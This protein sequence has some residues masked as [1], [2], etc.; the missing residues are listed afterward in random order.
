MTFSEAGFEVAIL[1]G[2]PAGLA[3]GYYAK[4]SGLPFRIFEASP[5][6]GGNSI[7]FHWGPFGYDSGAHRYHDKD[8]GVTEEL[9]SLLGD[10]L[11]KIQVPSQ[12]YQ[13]G[14]LVDFPLSPLNVVIR[15]GL[16]T[17]LRG[18]LDFVRGQLSRPPRFET[19]ESFAVH[20]Y[21]KTI[22]DLFLLNYTEKLWGLPCDRLSPNV[23]GKRLKGLIFT[24]FLK[25]VFLG[26]KA[27]TEHLDGSFYYPGKGIGV[28]PEA[29]ARFCGP[30]AI[31]TNARVT[32]VFHDG[33]AVTGI[34]INGSRQVLAHAAVSTLPL[35]A[36]IA[37]LTP[38]APASIRELAA[39]LEFRDVL[40]VALFVDRP[41]I[42]RNASIYFP[43]REF[44][45]TRLYEPKNRSPE[46]APPDKTCVVLEIPTRRDHPFWSMNEKEL[47]RQVVDSFLKTG[48]IEEREILGSTVHKLPF[49][50]PILEAGFDGKVQSIMDYLRKFRNLKISGRCGKFLYT[51]LHDM[52]MFGRE[53]A[54]ELLQERG[55]IYHGNRKPE[56]VE[57]CP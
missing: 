41:C 30:E 10:D 39:K 16:A 24:T 38:S 56:S 1:G 33:T 9:R 13:K 32:R 35:S 17:C 25:E 11:R 19:F 34:E 23:S 50:Y 40:L 54:A 43:S 21:G 5:A 51:H 42:S 45:F 22:A 57:K 29:L 26:N 7:T 3:A 48:F 27:K 36:L 6:V 12:I 37:A 28:I 53:I 55:R 46:L 31:E 49:A 8:A 44:C 4:K 2:G 20:T 14:K 52:M 15:L 47:T 18:G